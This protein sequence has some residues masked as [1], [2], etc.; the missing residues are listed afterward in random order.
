MAL[1]YVPSAAQAIKSLLSDPTRSAM[2]DKVRAALRQLRDDPGH[3]SVRRYRTT[4]DVL[5]EGGP[6]W[7]VHVKGRE[8][9]WW[10]AWRREGDDVLVAYAGPEPSAA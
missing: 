3:E 7:L 10:V 1:V 5:G 2:A 8:E 9:T 4:T 6:Y